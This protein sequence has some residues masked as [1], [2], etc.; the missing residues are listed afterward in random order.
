MRRMILFAL[1]MCSLTVFSQDLIVTKQDK[2]IKAKIEEVSDAEIRYKEFENPTGPTFVVKTT[3]IS[4]V[5]YSNGTVKNYLAEGESKLVS[6]EKEEVKVSRG[7]LYYKGEKITTQDFLDMTES[8]C[9]QAFDLRN[10]GRNQ[11]TA[12]YTLFA[13]GGALALSSLLLDDPALKI[14]FL[15]VG[16]LSVVTSVPLIFCGD[17][18]KHK[19]V[20]VYNQQC[21]KP[22]TSSEVRLN[23]YPKSVGLAFVF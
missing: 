8:S 4:T 11:L 21:A 19:A 23:V 16:T 3:D 12:G 17:N 20:G 14:S 1:S 18:K 10:K 22:K 5:V 2:T 15:A 6:D 9:P 7:K 13:C